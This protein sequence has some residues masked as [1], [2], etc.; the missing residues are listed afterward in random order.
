MEKIRWFLSVCILCAL[1]LAWGGVVSGGETESWEGKPLVIVHVKTMAPLSFTGVNGEL[2]GIIPDY[3]RVWSEKNGIPIEY[4]LK[5]WPETLQMIRD[6]KADLHGGLYF[7]DERD[8]FLDFA[9][10]YI[11]L[12]A[13]MFMQ[14]SLGLTDM[15]EIGDRPV[16]VLDQGFSEYFLRKN[17]P[18]L[19]LVPF[20]TSRLMIEAAVAGRVGGLLIEQATLFYL[21][22]KLGK[23]KEFSS[24]GT[25]YERSL[26]AA[27]AKG[28]TD[29]LRVVEEGMDRLTTMDRERVF[30]RWVVA[31]QPY[32][33]WLFPSLAFGAAVLACIVLL[34]LVGGRRASGSADSQK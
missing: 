3:W 33:G 22:G 34:L 32:P 14:S 21:L 27:V 23:I 26:Y 2:K 30:R 20:K 4:V 29:L 24:L 7:S 31:D 1:A 17:Y 18:E 6:G 12:G 15:V 9:G 11:R 19:H 10:S 8:E 5:D 25:L 16:A 13:S 28:N